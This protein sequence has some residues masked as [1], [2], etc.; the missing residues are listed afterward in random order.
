[1][2]S[3][4]LGSQNIRRREQGKET[5]SE[6]QK[7]DGEVE[8]EFMRV[9]NK[10]QQRESKV[11]ER[12]RQG[13]CQQVQRR[14]LG[15]ITQGSFCNLELQHRERLGRLLI[16]ASGLADFPV[17]KMPYPIGCGETVL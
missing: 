17:R 16:E 9:K 7:T 1:M 10:E 13:K 3:S 5:A 12:D 6:S 14:S 2:G 8:R 4:Q 11:E 15:G